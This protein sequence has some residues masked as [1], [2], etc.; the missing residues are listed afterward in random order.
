MF[1]LNRRVD[2]LPALSQQFVWLL[3]ISHASY[4]AAKTVPGA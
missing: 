2:N 1:S 3:G 4:L